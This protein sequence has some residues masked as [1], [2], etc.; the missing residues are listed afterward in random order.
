MVLV[1]DR[2][3]PLVTLRLAFEA[4]SKFDPKDLPGCREAGERAADR[5]HQ[6]PHL[7]ADRRGT[8]RSGRRPEGRLRPGR[9]DRSGNALAENL[10]KLLDLLADVALNAA[11]PEDE[12]KL[13]QNSR[14]QELLSGA[15]RGRLL[16]RREDH[17]AGLRLASLCPGSNPTPESIAKLDRDTLVQFR[18]AHLAPNNAVLI[19]L[20]SI[21]AARAD[22]G[23][24]QGPVRRMGEEGPGR[25]G[26]R[27]EFPAA[28]RAASR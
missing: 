9:A 24:D 27:P 15:F 1:E 3:F 12:V 5:G 18:D 19:L 13:Y 28:K 25:R 16:G 10:P 4:G 11:F 17:G 6:D 8:G 23:L 20:G 22:P 7:A 14:T 21:P 26:P 2:R